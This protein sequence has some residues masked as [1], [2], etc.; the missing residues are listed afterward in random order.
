MDII[1]NADTI[2]D[3]DAATENLQ[4]EILDSCLHSY[5]I[6][7]IPTAP[8]IS[9]WNQSLEIKKNEL[10]TLRR[11]VEKSPD[12]RLPKS[13]LQKESYRQKR[14][15]TCQEKGPEKFLLESRFLHGALFY[16]Q[17]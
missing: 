17:N 10:N 9:W 12:Q 7:K 11:R 4:L 8:N 2:K 15:P 14:N 1:H 6:R 3:L 5:N 13:L 16:Q